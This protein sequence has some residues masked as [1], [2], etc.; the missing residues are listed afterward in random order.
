[1]IVNFTISNFRSYGKEQ[2]FNMVAGKYRDRTVNVAR[3]QYNLSLL[4]YSS[5]FGQNG[6]GKTN[7]AK[8]LFCLKNFITP[9]KTV[10]I[11]EILKHCKFVNLGNI[12]TFSLSFCYTEKSVDH[13]YTFEL[14]VD[15]SNGI[16]SISNE[17]LIKNLP[18]KDE[19]LYEVSKNE[20]KS[21]CLDDG[22]IKKINLF[23][24]NETN[25]TQLNSFSNFM[26]AY[27]VRLNTYMSVEKTPLYTDCQRVLM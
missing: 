22:V 11:S 23:F 10:V 24:K 15:N 18:T 9:D 26:S 2:S 13:F 17:R 8:A 14:S 12:I 20:I 25:S 21:A 27:L 5:I 4:K 19:I 7:L 1:M 3:K 16:Y 6:S